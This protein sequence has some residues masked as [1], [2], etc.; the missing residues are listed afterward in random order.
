MCFKENGNGGNVNEHV[1][2]IN[3]FHNVNST[4]HTVTN[5]HTKAGILLRVFALFKLTRIRSIRKTEKKTKQN[6]T[7][8]KQ[9]K[10]KSSKQEGRQNKMQGPDRSKDRET[11]IINKK[12][13][14]KERVSIQEIEECIM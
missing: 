9:T 8:N 14:G 3:V 7:K 6:K 10:K 4:L 5:I 11:E 12:V 13:L 1:N 2:V